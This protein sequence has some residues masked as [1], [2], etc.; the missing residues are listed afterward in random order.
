MPQ[1]AG[2]LVEEEPRQTPIQVQPLMQKTGYRLTALAEFDI[3]ARVLSKSIYRFDAGAPLMP[4]D[5]ALGWGL[6]SDSAV[7]AKLT[8]SQAD[9]FYF[10]NSHDLP[11]A[12]EDISRHSANMHLIPADAALEKRLKAVREGELVHIIGYLVHASD[13]QGRQWQSSL[14]RDDT[15]PGACE[16]IWVRELTV[17]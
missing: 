15:G 5:L 1:P 17:E 3:R 11:A 2:I 8:I 16:I 4:V 6:M 14:S 10:W 13:A 12:P 9:R 7:L